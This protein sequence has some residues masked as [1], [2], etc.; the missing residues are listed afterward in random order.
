MLVCVFS[1]HSPP[2]ALV[3]SPGTTLRMACTPI[4]G[5]KR[6]V[7][8]H[9]KH[10]HAHTHGAGTGASY[11]SPGTC[12]IRSRAMRV[13]PSHIAERHRAPWLSCLQRDRSGCTERILDFRR[14]KQ[15]LWANSVVRSLEMVHFSS[16]SFCFLLT[17]RQGYDCI[18]M[19]FYGRT[20]IVRQ[21]RNKRHARNTGVNL[22]SRVCRPVTFLP[23]YVRRAQA[24]ALV[25]ARTW[26]CALMAPTTSSCLEAQPMA[27]SA[28][29]LL[30]V[31]CF[32]GLRPLLRK[33]IC[34]RFVVDKYVFTLRAWILQAEPA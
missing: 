3:C 1:L 32:F 28:A 19:V 22:C 25:R 34:R 11:P 16:A 31:E 6:K 24:T 17:V 4:G 12:V 20:N 15:R 26:R 18:S 21:R 9:N 13:L 10:S 8:V 30:W 2:D 14:R 33:L 5:R 27:S 7:R 29:F 23:W